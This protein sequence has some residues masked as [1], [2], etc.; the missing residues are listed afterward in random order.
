MNIG[1]TIQT[2]L[3]G[4]VPPTLRFLY[5]YFVGNTLHYHA[6]FT[7]DA[8]DEHLECASVVLTEVLAACPPGIELNETIEKN[9]I[10]PWCQGDGSNL[11]YLRYG[12]LKAT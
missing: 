3:L 5:A 6:V 12:E 1:K 4:E 8:T 9:D 2:A 10:I 11:W 7:N